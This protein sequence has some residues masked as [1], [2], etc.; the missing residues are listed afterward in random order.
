[1]ILDGM[2]VARARARRGAVLPDAALRSLPRSDRARWLKAARPIT[3]TAARKSWT[4]CAR[5][6]A[7]ARRSR[8]TTAAAGTARV[9][10]PPAGVTP[11]VRFANPDEG[12]IVVE[13]VVHGAGHV[14][15]QG[16]RRPHHRALRRHADLQLLR[17]GRRRRHGRHA[18][19]PRRRS[20]Q[21]HAAAD[22]HAA[23]AGQASRRCT[24]TCR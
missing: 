1:M 5:P 9:R 11:V 14:P 17:G 18:R 15:E 2:A 16:A 10:A 13:D 6:A 8:A 22:E 3:A 4:R 20:P 7:R 12:A 19:D 23:R 24:R 21:Q